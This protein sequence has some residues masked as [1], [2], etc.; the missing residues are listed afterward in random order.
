VQ[1]SNQQE[2]NSSQPQEPVGTVVVIHGFAEHAARFQPLCAALSGTG[3]RTIA[4]NLRGHGIE[5]QQP[6][7]NFF[8]D[9]LEDIEPII[10]ETP[11][12]RPLILLGQSMGG[13]IAAR[14]A[15][16]TGSRGI[17]GLVMCSPAFGLTASMPSYAFKVLGGIAKILPKIPLVPP[18]RDGGRALSRLQEEQA[19]FDNDP[20]CW[21]GWLGPRMATEL[22]RASADTE[23]QLQNLSIPVLMLWGEADTVISPTAIACAAA[24]I[25]PNLLTR[26]I[27]PLARHHLLV[28]VE[29]YQVIEQIVAWLDAGWSS[30]FKSRD[31]IVQ[32]ERI[33]P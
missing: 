2:W 1:N 9:Y 32:L 7:V 17:D 29:R 30:S 14:R 4:I 21:H 22:V 16:A 33:Q 3:W 27:L 25:N 26:V 8:D 10:L 20:R 31:Q 13:L 23:A 12:D 24:K 19:A 15:L 5:G 6:D 18:P 11:N 28:E